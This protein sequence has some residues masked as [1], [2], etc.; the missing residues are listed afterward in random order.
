MIGK[1]K[2]TKS[3]RIEEIKYRQILWFTKRIKELKEKIRLKKLGLMILAMCI[4][5]CSIPLSI[6]THTSQV[7]RDKAEKLQQGEITYKELT[8]KRELI[9]ESRRDMLEKHA[10]RLAKKISEKEKLKIEAKLE[11]NILLNIFNKDQGRIILA[12]E[13]VGINAFETGKWLNE[14]G[15]SDLEG[16]LDYLY[17]NKAPFTSMFR[18]V[19][20]RGHSGAPGLFSEI[21]ASYKLL[22]KMY[23]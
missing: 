7:D 17:D 20:E 9:K 5:S 15:K 14:Y 11:R 8:Y 2:R 12:F 18:W 19:L 1:P 10:K 23:E 6:T 13:R 3:S 21:R 4:S 16:F 22:E